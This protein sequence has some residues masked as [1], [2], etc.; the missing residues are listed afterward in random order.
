MTIE[1]S[2]RL[3]LDMSHIVAPEHVLVVWIVLVELV[4]ND[5]HLTKQLLVDNGPEHRFAKALVDKLFITRRGIKLGRFERLR[6]VG[7]QLENRG[8]AKVG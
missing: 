1:K 2:T 6:N 7:Q 3:V 5:L 4:H 8:H